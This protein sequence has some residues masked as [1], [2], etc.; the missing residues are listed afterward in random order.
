MRRC[1]GGFRAPKEEDLR[2]VVAAIGNIDDSMLETKGKS[3]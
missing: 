3:H 2:T 1:E